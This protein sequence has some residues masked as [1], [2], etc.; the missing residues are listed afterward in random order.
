MW[1]QYHMIVALATFK[2]KMGHHNNKKDQSNHLHLL[3]I[4]LI[5]QRI[6]MVAK[7]ETNKQLLIRAIS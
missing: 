7:I 1:V 3:K 4:E 6:L 5:K 2:I